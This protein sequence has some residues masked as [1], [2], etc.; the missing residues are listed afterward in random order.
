MGQ[1]PYGH[2]SSDGGFK[3]YAGKYSCNPV[4][5]LRNET[6]SLVTGHKYSELLRYCK[7]YCA[8]GGKIG[9]STDIKAS[10]DGSGLVVWYCRLWSLVVYMY[11]PVW[12][13]NPRKPH[14][15]IEPRPL[16]SAQQIDLILAWHRGTDQSMRQMG[17]ALDN[18]LP[19]RSDSW[20]LFAPQTL[21]KKG[22]FPKKVTFLRNRR[23]LPLD[24]CQLV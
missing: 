21:L 6:I 2:P 14:C 5:R 24:L 13:E 7:Q 18:W 15:M 12:R 4:D 3:Q 17:G 22:N 9:G 19:Q 23:L 16:T 1:N 10:W 20:G 11:R 8:P